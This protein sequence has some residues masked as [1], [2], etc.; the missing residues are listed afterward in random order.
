MLLALVAPALACAPTVVLITSSGSGPPG[1]VVQVTGRGFLTTP[2]A[3]PIEI[4]WHTP[5]GVAI[6]SVAAPDFTVDLTVP[7]V[8]P[9][10]AFIVASQRH[11][12]SG[13][14]LMRAVSA[15][16][17]TPATGNSTPP[18]SPGYR[19][20]A[21][22][23]G[24]FAFGSAGYHG[25]TGGMALHRPIVGMAPS[26]GGGYWLV[27]SDGGVF[28]FG[29]AR[30]FGSMGGRPLSAPIVGMSRTYT[31]D[32]YWLVAS[33]G[34]IFA[35]GDAPFLG[36]T[37]GK[38]LV[39]PIVGMSRSASGQGYVL[40]AADGG[41]FAFGDAPFHGS[42]G[43]APRAR[44]VVGIAA[45][46]T[47]AYWLADSAGSVLNFGDAWPAV[48]E[49]PVPPFGPVVGIA[50]SGRSIQHWLAGADGSVFARRGAPF[51]GSAAGARLDRPIVGITA[52]PG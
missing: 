17:V 8:P 13:G 20:V 46:Q 25:S 11:R 44:A 52:N 1:T 35:F 9:S 30:F 21:A 29:D 51:L 41:V 38:P 33:D 45:S 12:S 36:S 6:T 24:V 23:G 48:V 14:F 43:G 16:F 2:E 34:G 39:A 40:A 3:G 42:A 15:F 7:T 22:D 32:G 26:T 18:P 5:G 47:F 49:S 4:G 27:G 37:G 28:A 50:G 31:G 10:T 19:L